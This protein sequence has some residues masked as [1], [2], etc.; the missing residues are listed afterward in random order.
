MKVR[1]EADA[2]NRWHSPLSLT[3]YASFATLHHDP[4][5]PMESGRAYCTGCWNLLDVNRLGHC[6]NWGKV[7]SIAYKDAMVELREAW[8]LRICSFTS[9]HFCTCRPNL[10]TYSSRSLRPAQLPLSR[11]PSD[12]NMCEVVV[13]ADFVWIHSLELWCDSLTRMAVKL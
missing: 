2:Q 3:S 11:W 8:Y 4:G 9:S 1:K 10:K 6:G 12:T 5:F 13:R 7:E